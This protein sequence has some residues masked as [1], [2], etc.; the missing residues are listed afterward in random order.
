MVITQ[1]SAP[2]V[3]VA[4]D[5][6]GQGLGALRFA[7][8]EARARGTGVRMVHVLDH[9]DTGQI[10][11]PYMTEACVAAPD[12]EFDWRF[13]RGTLADELV[14]AAGAGDLLVLG[15]TTPWSPERPGVSAVITEI[16][17]RT[18][19]AVVV[20]PADWRA[21]HHHRII[22]GVKSCTN[23]G[24][25]LARAF[26][27]ASARSAALEIVHVCD[28]PDLA[29]VAQVD[30]LPGD[31]H[32]SEGRSLQAL[33]R[34]W[35]DVFPDVAVETSFTR[36]QPARVLVDAA[37]EADLLM[38]A[39]HQRDLRH[40]VRLGPVPRAVLGASDVPVEVVPLTG[41]PTPAPL[42]LTRSGTILKN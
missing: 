18:A 36:G 42:V 7:I 28:V 35:S 32:R 40:L 29:A 22:V 37:T 31:R 13:R 5:G 20:V 15:Q 10:M 25:L 30:A 12:V 27:E 34:D 8:D 19:A 26:A 41:A 16:A 38:I 39:R 14:A 4:V 9:D 17:A 24:G 11:D 23:A 33:A 1:R 21:R 3:V 6:R 2:A